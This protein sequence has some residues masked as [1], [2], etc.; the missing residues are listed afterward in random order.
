MASAQKLALESESRYKDTAAI[1]NNTMNKLRL[2][3][4]ERPPE[5]EAMSRNSARHIV[6]P[7]DIGRLDLLAWDYYR[8]VKLWWIIAAVNDLVNCFDDMYEGQSLLIPNRED[9]NAFVSRAGRIVDE[10]DG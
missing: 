3:L 6:K 7:R 1:T 2:E 8:D 9:V 5:I 4:W 10:T